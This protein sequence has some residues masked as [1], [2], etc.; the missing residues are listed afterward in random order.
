[1]PDWWEIIHGLNPHLN[2]A[3]L[4]PDG[5]NLTNIQEFNA[6]TDPQVN[7]WRGPS[8]TLS[9][10][11]SLYTIVDSDH[12]GIHD[13]WEV[14]YFGSTEAC[15]PLANGDSDNLN[16][17][18]EFISGTDPK[19]PSSVL[20]FAQTAEPSTGNGIVL[21]WTSAS[22]KLYIIERTTNLVTGFEMPLES[23]V[24]ATPPVNTYTDKTVTVTGPY[25][26]RI[27]VNSP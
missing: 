10:R 5:D 9:G 13:A 14:F 24:L 27:R 8:S 21:S 6:G 7:D 12:D 3:L 1:M 18:Q 4:D 19:D 17:Y 22:N 26:Y 20:R 15:D 11:F 23:S 25:F 2:D 16:N